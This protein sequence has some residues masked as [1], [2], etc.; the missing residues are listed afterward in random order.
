MHCHFSRLEET[1]NHN[2]FVKEDWGMQSSVLAPCQNINS[3]LPPLSQSCS[4]LLL[5]RAHGIL[6][7]VTDEGFLNE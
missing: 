1:L 3:H 2:V 7:K 5:D 4:H 6:I